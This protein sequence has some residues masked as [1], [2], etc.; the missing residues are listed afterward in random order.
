M[1]MNKPAISPIIV[2]SEI[3][4]KWVFNYDQQFLRLSLELET[5]QPTSKGSLP[6]GGDRIVQ[7]EDPGVDVYMRDPEK[8]AQLAK[9]VQ[10]G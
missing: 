4:K 1:P 10:H 3:G 8:S 6:G 9:D 7:P 2:F 5:R